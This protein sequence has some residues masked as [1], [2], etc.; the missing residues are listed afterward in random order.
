YNDSGSAVRALKDFYKVDT[1]NILVVHDELALPFG[2]VRTRN[3]GSD[4]GNNGMKSIIATI[5]PH[6][7]RIRIGTAN[8]YTAQHDATDFVLSQ[9]TTQERTQLPTVLGEVQRL[10]T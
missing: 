3:S 6:L 1:S 4:A 9:F 2:T 10:I 5:G 8:E 7:A